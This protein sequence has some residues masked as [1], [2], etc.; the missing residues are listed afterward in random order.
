MHVS[1]ISRKMILEYGF[2][3]YAFEIIQIFNTKR[4]DEKFD[5]L[6]PRSNFRPIDSSAL[7]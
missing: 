7:A 2:V 1:I 6:Q 3:S 4:L 5:Y